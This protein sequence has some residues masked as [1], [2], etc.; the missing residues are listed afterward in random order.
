MQRILSELNDRFTKNNEIIEGMSALH[1]KSEEFLNFDVAEPFARH[2]GIDTDT[3]KQEFKIIPEIIALLESEKEIKIDTVSKFLDLL[4]EYK[5]SFCESYKLILIMVIIPVSSA[6]CEKTFSSMKRLQSYLRNAMTP[7]RL[8]DL[9][10]LNIEKLLSRE[11]DM[12]IVID[13]FDAVHNNRRILL[14]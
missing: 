7:D 2:Y 8:D 9:A 4:F 10:I 6:A 12:N 13:K 14:H 11:I 3:L 1:P 5:N